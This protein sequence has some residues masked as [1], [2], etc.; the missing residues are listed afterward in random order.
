MA[1]AAACLP[2]T[3]LSGQDTDIHSVAPM[4]PDDGGAASATGGDS[5]DKTG[6]NPINFSFDARVYN[7]YQWLNTAGDGSQNITTFEFRAPFADG[8]WQFRTRLRATGLKA[9]FNN[10]GRDDVDER[11]FGD[12]DFRLLTVVHMNTQ[13]KFA[14][15]TGLEVFLNTASHD[16]LGSNAISLGPQVFAVFFEPFGG[17]FDL[18]APA[19]QHKFSVYEES[20]ANR[21]HQGFIDVFA[22]KTSSDKKKWVLINPTAIFDYEN[23]IQFVT[24]DFEVGM[25][26][27][28]VFGTKGHSAYLRPSVAIGNDR[29]YDYSVECGYKIIW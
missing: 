8:K 7:E 23:D 14:I 22:L 27:D 2:G 11:G 16:A 3:A 26:L 6:T 18:I 24:V 17:M 15:A 4:T 1:L 12:M 10:D 19:Y 29:P 21:V 5:S 25:M 20:G 9:D 28:D 13:K